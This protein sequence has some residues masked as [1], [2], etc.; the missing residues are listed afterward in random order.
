MTIKRIIAFVFVLLIIYAGGYITIYGARQYFTY[1]GTERDFNKMSPDELQDNLNIKGSIE[2]V[3]RLLYIGAPTTGI[4]GI[5]RSSRPHYYVMPLGYE[6][7]PKKQEYCIIVASSEKDIQTLESLKKKSPVPLD[8]NAPR[9]E[10]RAIVYDMD[11][12]TYLML[13]HYL[14]TVYD[15]EFNLL[16]HA[17][18][19]R[20]IA[21]YVIMVK[22]K[23]DEN[24]LL[25]I[26]VGASAVLIGVVLLI[27]LA[28]ST[29]KKIHMY[30]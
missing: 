25:P 2:T 5:P 11:T 4:F 22:G 18:V 28:V 16:T 17:N 14:W 8:P 12:D 19:K 27:I 23:A 30:D 9:L 29:Y 3:T 15:T 26:T 10:F 1:S 20:N 7:E 13:E 6:S 24:L 21:P